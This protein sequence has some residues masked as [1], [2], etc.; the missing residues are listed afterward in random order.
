[1]QT[2]YMKGDIQN[3]QEMLPIDRL[4][5]AGYDCVITDI[6][7]NGASGGVYQGPLSAREGDDGAE[8]VTWLSEQ[9]FCDGGVALAGISYC[10]GTQFLTAA[11]RPRG[12]KCIIPGVG[13]TDFYRDWTH[14]GGIPQHPMWAADTFLQSSQP[15]V[16]IK[17]ALEFYYC[18]AQSTEEDGPL[19]WERSPE[20]T[21]DQ[22][23]VP[24]LLLLGH[25]DYFGRAMYR[26]FDRLNVPKRLV[27]GPWGHEYPNDSSEILAWLDYWLRG[28]GT[29]PAEGDSVISS[30]LGQE[31]WHGRRGQ[32]RPESHTRIPVVSEYS[33]L[34]VTPTKAGW[35]PLR[36][37][38][39][40][41]SDPTGA[42][43]HLWGETALYNLSMPTETL[44]EG[45]PLLDL[46]FRLTGCTNADVNVRLTLEAADG[47][48]EQISEGRLRLSH[49]AIDES[50]SRRFDRGDIELI[51][52]THRDPTDCASGSTEQAL[53]D[54]LP[55]A[56]SVPKGRTLQLGLSMVRT[57][58]SSRDADCWIDPS[59]RLLLP[60]G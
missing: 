22:I 9:P 26:A 42:G 20:Q 5:D 21:L 3:I 23:D 7:G 14:F 44:V 53:I 58:G 46:R 18:V 39:R 35:P 30:V 28:I 15:A 37:T 6:R 36:S 8:L 1:M 40:T 43:M 32:N 2:P 48:T 25:F 31:E 10:A 55:T 34:V 59:T 29:N 50:A 17:P 4:V 41:T 19:F 27:S 52:R 51:Y 13:M 38:P 16:S 49:R 60:I 54:L 56:F 12:L 24:A 47:S 11:R 45:I 33:T 57:D